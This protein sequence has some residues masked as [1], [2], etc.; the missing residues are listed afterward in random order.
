MKVTQVLQG[1][2][3]L[4]A[5]PT[6]SVGALSQYL[7][8]L[9]NDV[10]VLA[11]GRRPAQWPFTSELNIPAGLLV[12][13]GLMGP[14]ALR[15]MQDCARSVRIMHGHGVWR[16]ANLFPLLLSRRNRPKIVWSPRGM[17]TPWSWRRRAAI[18]RPFWYLLQ[19]RALRRVDCFHATAPSE[20]DDIRARG[21][22]QPVAIVP[23]GVVVPDLSDAPAR[24]N[25]V[26]FLSRIH[27]KKGL[28]LLLPVWR[29]IAARFPGWRLVIAGPLDSAYAQ[30]LRTA[31]QD[32]PRLEFVGQVLGA[33]KRALLASARLF[34]LPTYSENFGIAIAEALA[35]GV[36]VIT[37][38]ATPW[39]GV[40]DRACGWIIEPTGP[41]LREAMICALDRDAATLAAMGATGRQWMQA[42]FGWE[43]VAAQMDRVYRWLA[44]D[45][46]RPDCVID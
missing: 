31:A 39:A 16:A 23:N 35:H 30:K 1:V 7:N 28:D 33:A 8:A 3:N 14:G 12:R 34:V 9:G 21:F 26:V 45:E 17:F 19:Q 18:K 5:G 15:T 24:D 43:Q 13:H 25:T 32:I 36:P 2:D 20:Y 6:Y 4:S 46:P 27:P 22:Q 29:D 37:T 41:A 11:F 38:H 44:F 42:E 40:K 10:A